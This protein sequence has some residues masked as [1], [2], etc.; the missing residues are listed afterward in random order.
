MGIITS[1]FWEVVYF[2]ATAIVVSITCKK[3]NITSVLGYLVAGVILGPYVLN[4]FSDV[5]V[6]KHIA[7]FGVVFLLFTIGLELPWERLQELK[8][9]VFGMGFLQVALTSILFGSVALYFGASHE[10]A[11]LM[12]VGLS[13]SSTAVVLQ[14]LSDQKEITSRFGRISF[15][16]LLFQDLMVIVVLV[17]VTMAQGSSK[18]L[19]TILGLS[20]AKVISV[21]I[22]FI[23]F[24]RYLL[25]PIYGTI[26]A[27]RNSDLFFALTLLIILTTSFV[28]AYA[29]LSLGLG[30]FLG[31]LLL[32][33]TEYKHR[34]EADIK[35]FRSLLLGLFFMTVGMTLNPQLLIAKAN[36]IFGILSLVILGKISIFLIVTMIMRIPT[37]TA[38]QIAILMA[39]GS[40]FVFVLFKEAEISGFVGESLNQIIYLVVV[41]SMM[42]SPIL[43]LL[44]PII[45][46]RIGKDIGL[47]V[48]AAADETVDM[49]NHVIIVGFNFVGE[50]LHNILAIRYIPH[51][52]ID[53]SVTCVAKARLKNYPIFFGDA[54]KISAFDA[55]NVSKAKAVVVSL[56]DYELSQKITKILKKRHPHLKV[57]VRAQDSA[58]A[59]QI[60]KM[61]ASPIIPEIFAPSFQLAT[62]VFE[63]F[64]ING[65]QTEMIIEKYRRN[66]FSAQKFSL[67]KGR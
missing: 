47:S 27:T 11:I 9:Y 61:G 63:L 29:G 17:W 20:V 54:K 50:S 40:E 48:K 57:F 52:I 5:E 30:A 32:A 39:G 36:I 51:I 56:D 21:F 55:V 4:A 64:G 31:G 46:E 12:G 49:K 19:L 62:A 43:A 10:M 24:G 16:T 7:E 65:E 37:K 38:I 25:R 6:S 3:L 28:T 13:F 60:Q 26:V 41:V 66:L 1:Q 59:I 2:L 23:L 18:S 42:L 8:R 45:A 67:G 44:G 14:I 33:E 22:G 53:M 34:V 35:P 15:S 58:Q